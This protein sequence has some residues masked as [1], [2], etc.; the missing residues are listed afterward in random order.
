MTK[1]SRDCLYGRVSTKAEEQAHSL[2]N[3]VRYFKDMIENNPNSVLVGVYADKRSG[4]NT[5]QRPQFM[6]MV[7]AVRRGEID[8]IYT[9][10]IIRFGRSVYETILF[11]REFRA[12]GVS[13]FFE[14]DNIDTADANS[15]F[16]LYIHS[17]IGEAELKNMS[18]NVKW[19]A[20]KRYAKG[21]VELSRIYG[22]DVRKSGLVINPTEAA[23]VRELFE[24]YDSG[25]EGLG[26]IAK[27]LNE[28]GIKKKYGLEF[29]RSTDVKR[30]LRSEK[31]IGCAITQKTYMVDYKPVINGGELPMKFVENNHEAI[32]SRELFD[33]VQARLDEASAA[34]PE[35][36]AYPFSP[37]TGRIKCAECGKSYLR[38]INNRNTPYQK[39]IW[40][41]SNYIQNGRKYCGGHNIR[42]KD[43]LELFLSAYNEASRFVDNTAPTANL[44]EIIQDMIL[45]ERELLSLKIKGYITSEMYDE[46]QAE[47]ITMIKEAE[48]ALL[49][50]A[51]RS[52]R[53]SFE[54]AEE[55][56]DKLG[57]Y[58]EGVEIDGFT[59]K[60]LFTNGAVVSRT[61]N[62]DTDRKSTWDKK[63]GRVS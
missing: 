41:C 44:S 28:R 37:F 29:W 58:F 20:R 11:V 14:D 51:R 8:R 1:K 50:E 56:D 57:A 31:H 40:S 43:L 48:A 32:V 24:R 39:W 5:R 62:N 21:S 15:D 55:Y 4:K 16:M 38:R 61:F 12:L 23:V 47:L 13:I 35:R 45:Q 25:A 46:R 2:I 54:A 30:V 34:V 22:F 63:L 6:A 53:T 59:I 9:K 26:L 3:Q 18:E 60:F 19:S 36:T 17:N 33:R 7:K 52:G 27:S 10:S 49:L 42:E